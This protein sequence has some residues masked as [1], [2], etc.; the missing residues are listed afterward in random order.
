MS[1]SPFGYFLQKEKY[2]M[3]VSILAQLLRKSQRKWDV[4]KFA[5][6]TWVQIWMCLSKP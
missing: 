4:G 1:L 6:Q 2:N 5:S 3:N